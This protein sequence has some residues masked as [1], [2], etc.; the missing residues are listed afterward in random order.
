MDSSFFRKPP[1]GNPR[2][3]KTPEQW[4]DRRNDNRS[5]TPTKGVLHQKMVSILFWWIFIALFSASR[6]RRTH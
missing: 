4:F 1:P 3:R 6:K 2:V 5:A